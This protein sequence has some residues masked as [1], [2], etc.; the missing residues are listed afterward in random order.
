MPEEFKQNEKRVKE[1]EEK[2][3]LI[4]DNAN[5]LITIINEN[6]EHEYINEKAYIDLLGYKKEEIIGKT[7]LT[8]LHPD[9]TKLTLKTLREGFKYGEG[10]NEMRIRHKDG[11]YIW[12]EHK[13]KTFI[14]VDG[15]R[16]AIIISRDITE[17]KKIEQEKKESEEIYRLISENANDLISI[18]NENLQ[19]EYINKKPFSNILGYKY[20]ELIGKKGIDF[21]HPDDREKLLKSFIDSN[22]KFEGPIEARVKHKRGHYVTT[23]TNGKTFIDKD[24]KQKF[25]VISRDITERKRTERIIIEE[26]KKL[27]ELSQIKSELIMRASHEFKTPLSSVYAA[28]QILLNNFKDQIGEKALEFLE[29]I[30]RGSQRLIQLIENLLDVSRLES[31]KLSL[32]LQKE[33][34]VDIINECCNDLKYWADKR[35]IDINIKLPKEIIIKIDKIRIEQVIIN[36]LSNAIKFTPP[37]GNIYI[38]LKV[39]DQWVDLSIRDTGIGLTKKERSL[40]FQK[41]GKIKRDSKGLDVEGSGLGLYISKEIVELHNGRILVESS[42]RD[43]GSTFTIRIPKSN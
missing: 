21:V 35:E 25:L 20:D 3:K 12:L 2:Y 31:S 36:L 19:F 11:H 7:P 16:K 24:N 22:K 40:L 42:G 37:K 4:L 39:H 18:F 5:D 13:G 33:N 29:M 30:Y 34:L 27:L 28:S 41:F 8:P 32:R 15:K 26:N 17:R 14:D 6:F 1:S 10:R 23:E 38:N 43:N 9:D